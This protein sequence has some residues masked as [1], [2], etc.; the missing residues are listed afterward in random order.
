MEMLRLTSTLNEILMGGGL[1][2]LLVLLT[3]GWNHTGVVSNSADGEDFKSDS[4]TTSLTGI[5][6]LYIR[7]ENKPTAVLMI[8]P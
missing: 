1:G 4:V 6:Y 3:G 2:F 7:G 8:S 5:I